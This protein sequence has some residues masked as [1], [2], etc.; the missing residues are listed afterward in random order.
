LGRSQSR[1]I[2]NAGEWFVQEH[3]EFES[4]VWRCDLV[5]ITFDGHGHPTFDHFINAIVTG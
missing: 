3:P 4:L 5:A 1:R 2:L